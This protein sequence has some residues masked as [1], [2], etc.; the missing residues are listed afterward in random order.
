M[1]VRRR[2]FLLLVITLCL[3]GLGVGGRPVKAAELV[4]QMV[5]RVPAETTIPDD[6]Y[7][8]ASSVT[9]DGRVEGDLF[10]WA[11]TVEI[12]GEIT[13]DLLVIAQELKLNGIVGDDARLFAVDVTFTGQVGDDLLAWVL[14]GLAEGPFSGDVMG[15]KMLPE[16]KVGGDLVL[17]GISARLEG[18][19]GQD[20]TTDLQILELNSQVGGR[21]EVSSVVLSIAPTSRFIGPLWYA[22]T[23]RLE[24][25]PA[26]ASQISYEQLAQDN[27]LWQLLSSILSSLIALATAGAILLR[28]APN[29]LHQPVKMLRYNH[30]RCLRFGLYTSIFFLFFTFFTAILILAFSPLLGGIVPYLFVF[31]FMF[32][33]SAYFVWLFS[34]V[35]TG[36]W[37]GYRFTYEPFP[38]LLIGLVF[39]LTA[40]QFPLLGGLA[41]LISFFLVVGALF[42]LALL[43]EA[44]NYVK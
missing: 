14:S 44:K 10:I 17:E 7:V 24:L 36:L 28:F 11:N 38:A 31:L 6:V 40:V 16:A 18:A 19:I 20:L 39:I 21:G 42:D 35:I 2:N 5:Y 9:I 32:W 41:Q 22:S 26:V 4:S 13:G 8:A 30:W 33:L 12:K 23:T 34:P 27:P 3:V 1:M 25:D 29:Q 37:L 43:E 15:L